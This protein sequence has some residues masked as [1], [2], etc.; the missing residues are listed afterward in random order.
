[1]TVITQ[2]RPSSG[3]FTKKNKGPCVHICVY[4]KCYLA[5]ILPPLGIDFTT[6]SCTCWLHLW[7]VWTVVVHV[8]C[9]LTLGWFFRS[10]R[11]TRRRGSSFFI[12]LCREDGGGPRKCLQSALRLPTSIVPKLT[13]AC[14]H[15]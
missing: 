1:M 15:I 13:Y 8:C 9:F 11:D 14:L 6:F 3:V 5:G 2:R 12:R 10:L 4:F 7:T